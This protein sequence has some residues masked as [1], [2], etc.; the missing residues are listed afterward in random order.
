[1]PVRFPLHHVFVL[2]APDAPEAEALLALGLVE[3]SSNIHS[4]QGTANRRF[5]FHNAMLE[6]LWVQ[7][8]GE[9]RR[10]PASRLGLLERWRDRARGTSP[11]GICLGPSASDPAARA[12]EAWEYRPAYLP[13]DLAIMV[14]DGPLDEPLIFQLPFGR[15]PDEAQ[16]SQRE[17][18]E[19]GP[20]LRE[21]TS[22]RVTLPAAGRSGAVRQ[23][24]AVAP[25][26]FEQ[27]D[28]H[29]MTLTFDGAPSGGLADLRPA[30]P[31]VMEW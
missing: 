22:V 13:N 7:D 20:G 3:G 12:F 23:L 31:L 21:L 6:L 15:R 9:A 1:M 30:L 24:E 18:L 16:A 2:T 4:G 28:A 25:V 11:F 26:T 5:F 27:G 29:A 19:H 8:E 10:P 14:A 17:P